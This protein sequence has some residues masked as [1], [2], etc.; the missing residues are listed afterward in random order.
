[1]CIVLNECILRPW[2]AG[3][4]LVFLRL[5]LDRI[6]I[7]EGVRGGVVWFQFTISLELCAKSTK[8]G[9]PCL[10]GFPWKA[11]HQLP[12]WQFCWWCLTY[13]SVDALSI[14]S[15][16]LWFWSR[17]QAGTN[18]KSVEVLWK[19][20]PYLQFFIASKFKSPIV[21]IAVRTNSCRDCKHFRPS[22]YKPEIMFCSTKEKP[23]SSRLRCVRILLEKYGSYSFALRKSYSFA[24]L[25]R[26]W[27][28]WM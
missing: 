22:L 2:H 25:R 7:L 6:W 3:F 13:F 14:T 28:K 21:V 27:A 18:Y 17:K 16:G 4:Y 26:Q 19:E 15:S 9:P 23:R 24:K 1:M 10:P 20:Q 8:Y 5:H 12:S 11:K